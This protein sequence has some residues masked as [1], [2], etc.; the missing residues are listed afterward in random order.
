M[1]IIKT[2]V[3]AFLLWWVIQI[4]TGIVF[5]ILEFNNVETSLMF[6]IIVS[7]VVCIMTEIIYIVHTVKG[8]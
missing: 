3:I 5:G 1:R 2:L 6:K 4:P 7:Y 8:N